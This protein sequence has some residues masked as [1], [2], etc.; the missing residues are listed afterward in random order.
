MM[1]I[2]AR[3]P[4]NA[5]LLLI[6][7]KQSVLIWG[8]SHAARLYPGIRAVLDSGIDVAQFARNSCAPVLDILSDTVRGAI[9]RYLISCAGR[10]RGCGPIRSMGTLWKLMDIPIGAQTLTLAANSR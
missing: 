9:K 5:T 1:S 4:R 2:S 6:P 7:I 10:R 8:D 3:L